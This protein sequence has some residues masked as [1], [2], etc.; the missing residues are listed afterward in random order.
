MFTSRAEYRLQLREDNADLRLTEIGRKLGVVDDARWDA[1]AR[2]RDVIEAEKARL[3][4]IWVRPGDL[5]IEQARALL[6]QPLEREQTLAD[7]LRRPNVS[8]D[9]L[10]N[11]PNF[12]IGV[13]DAVASEQV[14]I[15]A[16]YRG[17]IER[18]KDEVERLSRQDAV[19]LPSDLD[20]SQVTGLSAEVR[21]KLTQH[22]P[23]TVGQVRR[24]SGITPAAVSLLLVYLKKKGIG[25]LQKSA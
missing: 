16:K 1:F 18:Q 7:L 24:M 5:A 11:L 20:F 25:P 14:D 9:S 22:R 19:P 8:Y 2:K 15:Q 3:K 21:Q 23:E 17:Y 13:D 12:G 4:T 6:G 10:R